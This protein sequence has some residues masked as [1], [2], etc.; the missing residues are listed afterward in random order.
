MQAQFS[1]LFRRERA[2]VQPQVVHRAG[3]EL[4]VAVAMPA[5]EDAA[6]GVEVDG[7][8]GA[9]AAEHTVQVD[10]DDRSGACHHHMAPGVVAQPCSCHHIPRTAHEVPGGRVVH[11]AVQ[12]V[13]A[14]TRIVV[15]VDHAGIRGGVP[16]QP[17]RVGEIT[18]AEIVGRI[19]RHHH[20]SATA[21]LEGAIGGAVDPS[22][23]AGAARCAAMVPARGP[24]VQVAVEEPLCHQAV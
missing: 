17:G 18:R 21:E 15:L 20:V 6:G 4:Y 12:T 3:V 13:D 16:F 10:T 22:G 9:A 24:V 5:D 11:E 2:V 14:A 7:R 1:H 23:V 8:D 19:V